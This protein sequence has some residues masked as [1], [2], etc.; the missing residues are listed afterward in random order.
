MFSVRQM[1]EH[2]CTS[3]ADL[4]G[5]LGYQNTVELIKARFNYLARYPDTAMFVALD[6]LSTIVGW[7]H[8]DGTRTLT[9]PAFAEIMSLVVTAKHR[10]QGVGRRLVAEAESWSRTGGYSHLRLR[11]G[12][13]R[14]DEAH[15]FY[16]SLGFTPSRTSMLFQKSF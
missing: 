10:R 13:Q 1:F 12:M 7:V 15:M 5:E 2:D 9:S 3:I 11:S 14:A 16:S 4:S 8:V 6:T